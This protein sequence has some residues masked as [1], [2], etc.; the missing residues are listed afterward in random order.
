[1]SA[2]KQIAMLLAVDP[3][4]I[5]G[6]RL[7]ARQGAARDAWLSFVQAVLEQQGPVR[8][9]PATCPDERLIGGLDLA[10]TL[11]AGRPI[12]E[13]GL[14]ADV[15]GGVL[16]LSGAERLEPARFARIAS[17]FDRTSVTVERDGVHAAHDSRFGMIALDEGASDEEAPPAALVDRLAIWMS[18]DGAR[19][20]DI[21]I[22]ETVREQ[23]LAARRL[24]PVVTI[25]DTWIVTICQAAEALGVAS[26]RAPSLAVAVARSHAALQGRSAVEEA[27]V[28]AAVCLV[29]APRATRLPIEHRPEEPAEPAQP[30]PEQSNAL[31]PSSTE[32]ARETP[33]LDEDLTMILTAATAA[34]PNGLLAKLSGADATGTALKSG[35][36]A[37]AACTTRGRGRPLGSRQA[38]SRE[39]RNLALVDTLRAAAPWQRLRRASRESISPR[40]HRIEVRSSDFRVRK[41]KH[42]S[43]TATI[44]VVD[45]SGS[46]ALNRMAEVK[47]A[48]EL[49]LA[50]CYQRRDCVALIA[51]RG[52]KAELLLPPTRSLTRA[53]RHIEGLPGGGGTPLAT[54]LDAARELALAV[55]RKG[56]LPSVV[57]MTDGRANI[58]R[59][60]RQGRQSAMQDAVEAAQDFAAAGVSALLIDSS[61]HRN[62]E[63][64]R[65]AAAMGASYIALPY[66]SAEALSGAVR[67]ANIGVVRERGGPQ[68]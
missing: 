20:C 7:R 47:G 54:A 4:A 57:L 61:V 51:F 48:V 21:A 3:H 49:I 42:R 24:R 22:D 17:A 25:A 14:L 31:P 34:I 56:Q 41:L 50:D 13:R 45:A 9:C 66:A 16:M 32:D 35:G 63:A 38:R 40:P 2:G 60:G 55:R 6:V 53:R 62:S 28:R 1:M 68:R 26:A 39:R 19:V 29:L 33:R 44:F 27:D 11:A 65:L 18:L 67:S 5:G 46:Q 37:G 12:V 23:M 15:D 43:E 58:A 59:D 30:L 52:R 10:A 36:R 8:R 64:E